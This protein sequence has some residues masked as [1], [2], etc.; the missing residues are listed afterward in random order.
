[1]HFLQQWILHP[2]FPPFIQ[3]PL[4]SAPLG[5]DSQKSLPTSRRDETV[6]LNEDWCVNL[7]SIP[8]SVRFTPAVLTFCWAGTRLYA[9]ALILDLYFD[10]VH[11][12]IL[13]SCVYSGVCR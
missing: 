3:I 10:S 12:R 9:P 13:L 6:L 4:S 8:P 1:M 2:A 11:L 5:A 7:A